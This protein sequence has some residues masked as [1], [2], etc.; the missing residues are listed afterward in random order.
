MWARKPAEPSGRAVALVKLL[1]AGGAVAIC[2]FAGFGSVTSSDSL[3]T[4][5]GM[6]A[7][8]R[9]EVEPVAVVGSSRGDRLRFESKLSTRMAG[10]ASAALAHFVVDGG[11]KVVRAPASSRARTVR[12]QDVLRETVESPAQLEDGV[13][14]IRVLAAAFGRIAPGQKA[15]SAVSLEQS[16]FFRVRDGNA[17]PMTVNEWYRAPEVK[18]LRRAA[19]GFVEPLSAYTD[20]EDYRTNREAR[21][22]KTLERRRGQR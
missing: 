20:Y 7:S 14:Q 12:A 21:I 5:I 22:Q 8:L 19:K 9:L 16:A 10:D 6:D 2:A 3:P 15:D 18:R 17:E 1:L 4:T 11:G 13:Y